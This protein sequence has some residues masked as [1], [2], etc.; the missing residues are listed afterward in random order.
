MLLMHGATMKFI[1]AEQAKL[2]NTYKH[3]RLELLKISAASWFN[4]MR[5]VKHLKPNY[6]HFKTNG[7][8]VCIS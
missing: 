5:K 8:F 1:E 7:K 2:C 6:I 3:T 4:K